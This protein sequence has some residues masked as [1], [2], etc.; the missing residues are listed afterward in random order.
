MKIAYLISLAILWFCIA[1]QVWLLRRN[2]K[3][4]KELLEAI[5]LHCSEAGRLNRVRVQYKAALDMLEHAL[6]EDDPAEP[7]AEN[8]APEKDGE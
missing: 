2:G 4:R 1:L 8:E 3:T 5:Q 7:E 6:R